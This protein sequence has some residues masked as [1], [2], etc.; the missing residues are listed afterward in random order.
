MECSKYYYNKPDGEDLIGK[1]VASARM[2]TTVGAI[3][4][5][6]DAVTRVK[7]NS[8]IVKVIT[9]LRPMLYSCGIGVVF[10]SVTYMSTRIREKDDPLNHAIGTIATAPFLKSWLKIRNVDIAQCILWAAGIMAINKARRV[11][12]SG[13]ETPFSY[14]Y[15]GIRY[16]NPNWDYWDYWTGETEPLDDYTN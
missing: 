14:L 4:G 13:L 15:N 12:E 2:T 5:V 1:I 16:R 10:A 9:G 11:D 3:V 8:A 7:T 6:F